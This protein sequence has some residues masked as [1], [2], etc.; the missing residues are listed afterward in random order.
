TLASGAGDQTIKFWDVETRKETATLTGHEGTVRSLA[1]SPDGQTLASGSE[2]ATVRLWDVETRKERT[3]LKGHNDK[4]SAVVFSPR[5]RSATRQCVCGTR[6]PARRFASSRATP[7]RSLAR[8]SPRTA[9]VPSPAATTRQC[10]CGTWRPARC[11]A[12]S[13]DTRTRCR[14]WPFRLTAN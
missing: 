12:S 10:A 13:K 7:G 5:G 6:R 11:T 14:A 1:F 2:D 3:A 4:V 8:S 9:P